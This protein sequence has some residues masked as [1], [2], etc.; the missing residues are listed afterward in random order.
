MIADSS[1]NTDLET[2][3]ILT[4]DGCGT[5]S[6]A[7][8]QSILQTAVTLDGDSSGV[9]ATQ[10]EVEPSLDLIEQFTPAENV[11]DPVEQFSLDAGVEFA[12]EVAGTSD[13]GLFGKADSFLTMD[14]DVFVQFG[15]RVFE[16]GFCFHV[17][18]CE[19]T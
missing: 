14:S 7:V 4:A 10:I 13:G 17:R 9:R 6:N 1:N 2:G 18:S 5:V 8:E 19:R 3:K 12:N 11:H 16:D 15:E